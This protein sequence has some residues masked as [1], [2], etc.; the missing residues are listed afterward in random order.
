[1]DYRKKIEKLLA[2]AESP[3]E[4]EAKAALLKARE[5]MA[6]HK[7][8][9]KDVV[10]EK[11][12]E[13]IRM[14]TGITCSPKRDPWIL[15]IAFVIA[16]NHCCRSFRSRQKGKQTAEIGIIGL[17]DDI[18]LCMD[19]FLYAVSSVRSMTDALRKSAGVVTADSYGTGFVRGLSAAYEAQ[20][21]EKGWGLVLVA[22]HAVTEYTE[23]MTKQKR[24]IKVK[25]E[26]SMYEKGVRDGRKF[27]DQ[28]RIGGPA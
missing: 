13:V 25:C 6:E 3:N 2:L 26:E 24:P 7:I 15:G 17:S 27:H 22:P 4:N 23:S 20:Q 9:E 1:M 19:L 5:L 10:Q 8:A 11:E 18:G 21:E 14:M 16:K 12:Q 28:K